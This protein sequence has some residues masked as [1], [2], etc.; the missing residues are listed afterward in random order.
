[1]SNVFFV[2]AN[3]ALVMFAY[4]F[5]YM[6]GRRTASKKGLILTKKQWHAIQRLGE[7]I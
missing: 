2:F 6:L 7:I 1:M 3:T 4:V 5:G